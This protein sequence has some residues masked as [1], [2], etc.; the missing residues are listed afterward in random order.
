VTT[1]WVICGAGRG[2]GKTHLARKLCRILPRSVYAKLGHGAPKAGKPRNFFHTRRD[3]SA[4]LAR[5]RASCR[6]IVIESN[7]HARRGE[8][9]IIIF[10]DARAGRT[11]AR[12]DAGTLRAASHIRVTP[13]ASVSTWQ[14]VLRP[15]LDDAR[16]RDAVCEALA[17]QRRHLHGSALS[18]RSKVWFVVNGRRVFGPGLTEL[19]RGVEACGTLSEAAR[20]AGMSYRYA[21]GMVRAAEKRL[22]SKLLV[23]SPGGVGGG[24]SELSPDGSR[25]L[26]AFE[27]IDA[28]V[29]AYADRRFDRYWHQE[30]R[31]GPR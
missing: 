28:D 31:D 4:F 19:L 10:V 5:R 18:V 1:L 9:D 11:D 24:R 30:A 2:V 7:A 21:W 14:K 6:H 29:A 27:R 16:L 8:G 22:G 13:G 25:L 12:R 17:D 3:L 15:K 26:S 23:R 20:R